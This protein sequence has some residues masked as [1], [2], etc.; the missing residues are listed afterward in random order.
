MVSG[1]ELFVILLMLIFNAVFAAYEI[2][3]ASISRAK[4]LSLVQLKKKGAEDALF[5]KDRMEASLAVVQVGITIV[6]YIAAATGGVGAVEALVP[7]F[8]NQLGLAPAMAKVASL[9]ILITLLSS[10]TIIFAELIPKSYALN[11]KVFVCLTLSGTMKI[12]AWIGYPII[13][14]I[15]KI[16]KS[17]VNFISKKAPSKNSLDEQSG[18]HELTAAVSLARASRLLGAREEKIVLSAAQLSVR[19][20]KDIMLP[21]ADISMIPLKDT[22]SEALIKA[23][24]DMH[25]R[26]PVCAVERDPQTIQGY[27]NFKDIMA[28]LKLNPAEPSL[29]GIIR[30]I[31]NFDEEIPISQALEQMIMDKLHIALVVSK[32]NGIVGMVTMEDIIEELVG[33]IED[34]FDRVPSHIHPYG[35]GSWIMGGAVPMSMVVQTTGIGWDLR[36][37]SDL[38]LRLAD[39][40]KKKYK[41][42]L[43]GGE[44]VESNGLQVMVRKLRRKELS[45]AI[46]GIKK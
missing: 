38:S 36:S 41:A 37:E 10:L 26:F 11:N 23:H 32:G 2:A 34:E 35:D 30:P 21:S 20:I 45:E 7:F 33:D 39:W 12:F 29:K 25:T 17:V 9:V 43:Q 44:V 28:A 6:G 3:L 22:L 31:K 8:E 27:V 18:M 40:F 13:L 42:R 14:L 16:V 19:P 4:I 15:E 24:L 1:Y 46:V 5:M